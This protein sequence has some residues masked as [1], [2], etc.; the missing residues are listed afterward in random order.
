MTD[1][2]TQ[3]LKAVEAGDLEQV[4]TVIEES[5]NVNCQDER[6][7]SPL[8]IATQQNNLEMAKL[9]IDAGGDVNQRDN[10]LLTPWICAAANGFHKI[11][12]AGAPKA[13]ITLVNRF[14]GT[15]L[16]PSSEKG[17][18]KAVDVAIQSDVP[19][20]HVNDLEWTALQE[21]VI[22]GDGQALYSLI[23][24]LLMDHGADPTTLDNDGKTALDWAKEYEQSYIE[25]LLKKE[26]DRSQP[27][28]K[29]IDAIL[30]HISK[31][32]YQ[33]ANE[34][35]DKGISEFSRRVF[36]FLKGY[37]FILQD[38]YEQGIR[39]YEEALTLSG[40]KPEFYFYLAN[41]YREQKQVDKAIETYRKA[42]DMDPDYFFYRYHLSNYLREL[43]RH[44]EAIKEMD[45][46]LEQNPHRYDYAFHKANSLR[47]LGKEKVADELLSQFK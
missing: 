26:I 38:K 32:E 13:D 18:L 34:K 5:V 4:K 27:D 2:E 30:G 22:L 33:E 39:I 35:A 10:M 23:I 28:E 29:L 17:F 12:K 43:G 36:Y 1:K 37:T 20:N 31:E 3:L 19:V 24:R 45:I 47:V 8:M 40:G 15:A 21:A 16:L 25:S 11:L 42:I 41:A 7:R 9:L 46:L 44:E 6:G 14:G